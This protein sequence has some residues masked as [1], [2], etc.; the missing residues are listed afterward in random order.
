MPDPS[1]DSGGLRRFSGL[2]GTLIAVASFLIAVDRKSV[3]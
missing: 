1:D 3:V 2:P